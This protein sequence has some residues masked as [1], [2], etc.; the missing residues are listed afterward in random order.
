METAQAEMV[1]GRRCRLLRPV[2]DREG[3]SRFHEEARILREI[4]NLERRM[5]LVQFGDG[6]TTFLFPD[7]VVV[8]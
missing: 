4:V 1:E 5:F 3:K 2:R 6:S 8:D 7:E